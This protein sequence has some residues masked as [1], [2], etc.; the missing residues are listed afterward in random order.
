MNKTIIAVVITAAICIGGT[1]LL[2][3]PSMHKP[4]D[5]TVMMAKFKLKEYN[6][7]SRTITKSMNVLAFDSSRVH[8]KVAVDSFVIM[9]NWMSNV[10]DSI[11]T[12]R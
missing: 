2:H 7:Y 3:K 12:N 5:E 11:Y 1:L 9:M 4:T 10:I 6:D 8:R